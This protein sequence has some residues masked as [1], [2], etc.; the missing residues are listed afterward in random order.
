MLSSL[1]R[2]TLPQLTSV[3]KFVAY[4]HRQLDIVA[5][6]GVGGGDRLEV[7]LPVRHRLHAS[8]S[9]GDDEVIGDSMCVYITWFEPKSEAWRGVC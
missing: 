7:K 9:D 3:T 4:V 2:P 6:G 1:T 5:Q 8:V